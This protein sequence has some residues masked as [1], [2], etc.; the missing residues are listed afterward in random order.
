M[1]IKVPN[2]L[3]VMF[4]IP[5]IVQAMVGTAKI[6]LRYSENPAQEQCDAVIKGTVPMIVEAGI[7]CLRPVHFIER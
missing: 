4:L 5:M 1:D 3:V 7:V 6:Y 2:W